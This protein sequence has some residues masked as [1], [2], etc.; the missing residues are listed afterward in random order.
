MKRA[1]ATVMLVAVALTVWAQAPEAYTVD[2]GTRYSS[3][4]KAYAESPEAVDALFDMAMLYFDNSL[5]LRNLPLAMSFAKRAEYNY[6]VL[7]QDDKHGELTRLVRRGIVLA[8]VQQLK[9]AVRDAA[10]NNLSL[11]DDHTLAELDAYLEV[12]ADDA[13]VV[14]L[15]RSKRI[16]RISDADMQSATPQAYYH[17]ISSFPHTDEAHKAELMMAK[18]AGSLFEGLA[19]E[20]A[21]D[22]V[23]ARYAASPSVARAAAAKKS[24]IAFNQAAQQNTIAAYKAFLR[25]YPSS[26]E[27]QQVRD[28]LDERLALQYSSLHTA[29]EYADFADSNADNILA[30]SALAQIR[31]TITRNRDVQAA[32]MYLDRFRFDDH[33]N[34]VYA[35]YYSW[36]AEEGNGELLLKFE[37]ENPSSPMRYALEHDMERA[38]ILDN[39]DLMEPYTDDL[40]LI[41]GTY[42]R[43]AMG[44]KI[45]F[46]I[47]QRMLQPST[48][49][50]DYEAAVNLMEQYEVCFD[51]VSHS[52]YTELKETLSAPSSG[53]KT[54]VVGDGLHNP[55]FNAAEGIIYYTRVDGPPSSICRAVAKGGRWDSGADVAFSNDPNTSL[56]LF[57]FFDGGNK[58]L[59]G[60]DG[61]I[62]IA[63]RDNGAW[64][65]SDILPYPVNTDYIETDAFMLPDGSGMLLASDRPG[66]LN[67][68]QSGSYYHG[69]TALATDLYFIPYSNGL[70]GN[71][72]NLGVTVNTPYSERSPLMSSDLRTLYFI[73]DGRGGLGF[74][75][76][77]SVTRNSVDDWTSWTKPQ[78]L[79]REVNTGHAETSISFGRD[80]KSLLLATRKGSQTICRMATLGDGKALPSP[81][82]GNY[83]LDL[84]G[85]GNQTFSVRVAD[86]SQQGEPQFADYVADGATL[87]IDVQRDKSYA[88]FVDVKG[89]FV[90]AVVVTS[91]TS[92]SALHGYTYSE[93]VALDK[94]VPLPVVQFGA[95][96]PKPTTLAQM[97][98]E[99]LAR[100]LDKTP[101]ALVEIDID[102]AGLDPTVA[103]NLSLQRGQA[104]KESLTALGIGDNRIIISAY[105]NARTKRGTAEGVSVQF[106]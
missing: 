23:A 77:Y 76:I 43:Q 35:T 17:I 68:Q 4:N 95:S 41:F 94:A 59:V 19:D 100:F 79:G 63:E 44:K 7:M 82:N 13:E 78:N 14:R 90:P 66:G 3:V 37:E 70:W 73:T 62:W 56:T 55:C 93:L 2:F 38:S 48:D 84:L 16:R 87:S 25:R 57:S 104:I 12:F 18:V 72:I 105:G 29:K 31:R 36:Y 9:S 98:L 54:T 8:T 49:Q 67:L 5:P 40:S 33:Y 11:T 58:M 34:Q 21:I 27:S 10:F 69:D 101:S 6:L 81:S 85:M 24:R 46:V 64:R 83:T 80:E 88:V 53:V 51:P 45:A 1:L 91:R 61:D 75:D 86:I 22:T 97:Q 99:Q 15:A 92:R 28:L 89:C 30:D 52:E 42:I 26:D 96:S 106:R 20:T 71:P 32:R 60:N 65:V 74:G 103:Y 39:I 50:C 102:V 47:L